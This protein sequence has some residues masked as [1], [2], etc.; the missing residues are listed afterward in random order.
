[1]SSVSHNEV[2]DITDEKS[3][4]D[5]EMEAAIALSLGREGAPP[6]PSYGP[7]NRV[8]DGSTAMVPHTVRPT[9]RM[10]S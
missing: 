5:K 8:E 6:P 1:M 7:S 2:V 3:A 4:E 9:H 10:H